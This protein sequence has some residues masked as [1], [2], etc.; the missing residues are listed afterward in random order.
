M[1][2]RSLTKGLVSQGHEVSWLGRNHAGL[3]TVPSILWD[4]IRE[5]NYSPEVVINLAGHNLDCR[6]NRSNRLKI[7]ESRISSTRTLVELIMSGK[8]KPETYIGA[9]AIGFYQPGQGRLT[10]SSPKGAGFLT[11]VVSQ[12]ETCSEPLVHSKCRRI[13]FRFPAVLSN[14]G[15]MIA[16]LK[17]PTKLLGAVVLGNGK[18]KTPFVHIEDISKMVLFALSHKEMNG[19]YNAAAPLVPTHLEFMKA[20]SR[21]LRKGTFIKHTPEWPLKWALGERSGLVLDS[22]DVDSHKLTNSGF[23][24]QYPDIFAAI[25]QLT[26]HENSK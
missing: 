16:K 18:Q 19:I 5:S 4:E 12:W 15:G 23:V 6:W 21:G 25:S 7:L 11:E 1:V 17:T 14:E 3:G 20:F 9:S 10:E 22:M 26:S 8:W 13:L 24:F 2:G